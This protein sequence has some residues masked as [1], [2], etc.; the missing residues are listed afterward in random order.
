[1]QGLMGISF[2]IYQIRAKSESLLLSFSYIQ[3][4]SK[5]KIQPTLLKQKLQT[6][7]CIKPHNISYK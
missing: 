3:I 4:I 7:K 2:I 1:M 6:I 5:E